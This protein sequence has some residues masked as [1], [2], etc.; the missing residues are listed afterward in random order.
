M[1]PEIRVDRASDDTPY[2][3]T[4]HVVWFDEPDTLT[5]EEALVVVPADQRF[6]AEVDGDT[7]GDTDGDPATYA[8]IY[9][10]WPLQLAVPHGRRGWSP[11][12]G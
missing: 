7:D 9:G 5:L 8:G 12:P 6:A 1:A 3:A 11:A 2:R 10:V 4:D